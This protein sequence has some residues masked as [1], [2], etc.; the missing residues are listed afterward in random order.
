MDRKEYISTVILKSISGSISDIERQKLDF[1]LENPRNMKLYKRILDTKTLAKAEMNIS[2]M[3]SSRQKIKRSMVREFRK[4]RFYMFLKCVAVIVPFIIGGVVFWNINNKDLEESPL[5]QTIKTGESKAIL[6]TQN[7]EVIE[8]DTTRRIIKTGGGTDIEATGNGLVYS[9]L[10]S[11]KSVEKNT[12]FIPRGGEFMLTLADGTKV[13]LNSETELIYPVKFI[14]NKRIVQLN[15]E[16]YFDV[17]H[18]PNKP[19]IAIIN[20]VKVKVLGTSFNIRAYND[21]DK[22]VATLVKGKVRVDIKDISKI[23]VLSPGQQLVYKDSSVDVR[24][25][26]TFEYTA[27]KDGKFYLNKLGLGDIMK[28]LERWYDFDVFYQ[29]DEIKSLTFNG[30]IDKDM[31]INEVLEII[32]ETTPVR[33]KIKGKTVTAFK[34]YK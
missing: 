13:W 24:E 22:F 11:V 23:S 12:L 6:Y 19:F 14:G 18:N 25:V 5:V 3:S 16:A 27:W 2:S 20:G 32:E 8:L 33:F 17:A 30:L 26:N 29:N 15:G 28:Q 4:R 31:P 21:D 9:G 10:G 7:G 1:W 34:K